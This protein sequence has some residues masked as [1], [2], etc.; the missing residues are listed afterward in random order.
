MRIFAVTEAGVEGIITYRRVSS[1]LTISFMP[2]SLSGE[3]TAFV[4]RYT[5]TVG[6]SPTP[7]LILVNVEFESK[8]LLS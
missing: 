2:G 6:S 7:G 8:Y 3:R 4:M 5:N 1:N